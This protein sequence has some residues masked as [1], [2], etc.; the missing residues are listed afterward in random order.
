M[1]LSVGVVG[2]PSYLSRQTVGI[3]FKGYIGQRL[4]WSSC[5]VPSLVG[6]CQVR[7]WIT[8]SQKTALRNL[9]SDFDT[10]RIS[11]NIYVAIQHR[12][13]CV[14]LTLQWNVFLWK[15]AFLSYLP[16]FAT[17]TNSLYHL[18]GFSK[19]NIFHSLFICH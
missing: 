10:Y 4:F 17:A 19:T 2:L 16:D 12:F 9:P 3:A 13:F 7:R 18:S 1:L 8:V 14:S 15:T 11:L 5:R 6:F